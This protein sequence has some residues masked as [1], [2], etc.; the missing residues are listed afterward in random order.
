MQIIDPGLLQG[1]PEGLAKMPA[2]DRRIGR[3]QAVNDE[4]VKALT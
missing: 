2:F 4:V 3:V 1:Q